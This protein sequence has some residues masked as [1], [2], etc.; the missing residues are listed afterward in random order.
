MAF[1]LLVVDLSNADH[2]DMFAVG[3][4]TQHRH[5]GTGGRQVIEAAVQPGHGDTD[6]D[7]ALDLDP[8]GLHRIHPGG[9]RGGCGTERQLVGVEHLHM[10]V[11]TAAATGELQLRPA[12]IQGQVAPRQQCLRLTA[13]DILERDG[14]VKQRQQLGADLTQATGFDIGPVVQRAK[15]G[16]GHIGVDPQQVAAVAQLGRGLTANFH[17]VVTV[18][19]G[20]GLLVQRGQCHADPHNGGTELVF[21]SACDQRRQRFDRIAVT[22]QLFTGVA[23]LNK[24]RRTIAKAAFGM[25]ADVTIARV[26]G[27]CAGDR[28]HV[29]VLFDQLRLGQLGE[30]DPL[31]IAQV[32]I[33]AMNGLMDADLEFL[34]VDAV[35]E[36]ERDKAVGIDIPRGIVRGLAS[37]FQ[38]CASG[39]T[40]ADLSRGA[41]QHRA[42]SIKH[43]QLNLV[44]SVGQRGDQGGS[45]DTAAK[46]H[47]LSRALID[48]DLHLVRG[49]EIADPGDHLDRCGFTLRQELGIRLRRDNFDADR[50][51]AVENQL[52]AAVV[53]GQYTKKRSM[54]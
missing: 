4:K 14:P 16:G 44:L 38:R 27:Q 40:E 51:Q 20:L 8:T 42:A 49:V 47:R 7:L 19:V 52:L 36:V 10:D 45:G 41:S 39:V 28:F 22:C 12:Q 25:K 54:Q 34:R 17:Q 1:D 53:A 3:I 6:A 15:A 2:L 24:Y 21:D 50:R 29:A 18:A 5:A 35:V 13:F 11:V 26:V 23:D 43:P 33:E 37:K 46:F 48:A 30:S 31:L 9:N 32:I